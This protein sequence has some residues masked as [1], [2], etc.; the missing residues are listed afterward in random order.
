MTEP[1]PGFCP[2]LS[3]EDYHS[4]PGISKSG[5]VKLDRSPAHY[6]T[7][8]IKTRSMIVGSAFH[9]AILEP[10]KFEAEYAI[11]PEGM[12]LVNAKGKGW[13]G[14]RVLEG[15]EIL[16][17]KEGGNLPGMSKAVWDHPDASALLKSG[18]V[19]MSAFWRDPE[20]DFLCKC[21]PDFVT[22]GGIVV[23]L[24]SCADARE[25]PFSKVFFD[26]KYDW[27]SSWYLEGMN[28]AA[29][30]LGK[31]ITHDDFAFIAVEKL[32]PYG[33]NVFFA[34]KDMLLFAMEEIEVVKALY[35]RCLDSDKWPC[36]PEDAKFIQLPKWKRA[37]LKEGGIYD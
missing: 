27:Q 9:T 31:E 22:D 2:T 7:P 12:S 19:E 24:K 33:V 32:P 29:L 28:Q 15:K 4:G 1:K 13:K 6:R 20:Y 37:T 16:S 30:A 26:K 14:A 35:A 11:V 23:D 36:Y 18:V 25:F 3:N 5:L 34:D 8:T 21:R 10:E 17:T